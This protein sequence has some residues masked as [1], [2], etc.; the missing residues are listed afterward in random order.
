[1]VGKELGNITTGKLFFLLMYYKV[2][3]VLKANL[4]NILKQGSRTQRDSDLPNC[5]LAYYNLTENCMKV[6][7][8]N[9]C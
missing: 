8:E 5:L 7:I 4:S 1:M 3:N 2:T 9:I 6:E